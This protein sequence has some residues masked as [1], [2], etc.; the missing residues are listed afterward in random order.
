[1]PQ[2]LAGAPDLIL[3]LGLLAK[4]QEN[5][6]LFRQRSQMCKSLWTS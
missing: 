5:Q 1:M 2:A 3:V 4:A 6:D